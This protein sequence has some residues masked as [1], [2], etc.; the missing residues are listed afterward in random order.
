MAARGI[1]DADEAR[2]Y[3]QPRLGQLRAPGGLAGLT[4]AV[5]RLT[6]AV[7]GGERIGVFGDYDVD[8]VTTAALITSY[9]RQLGASVVPRV[10]RRDA[11]YGF[12]CADADFFAG[13]GC[14][15]VITG[16]CGTSDIDAIERAAARGM[17]VIVVD[18]HTVPARGSQHPALALINP[19]RG[20]ST[21]PFRAMASVGLS[22]YLMAALRTD[23]R[24]AGFFARRREPELR[25]LLDLVALGTVADLVPLQGENRILTATGLRYLS[26]R[27]RPG[28]A[29]LLDSAGVEQGRPVDERV[30]GWKLGP[31][32]NAPGRLGDAEPALALL[33]AEDPATA[34][35]WAERLETANQERRAAQDT[36]LAQALEQLGERDPGP[37]VVVAGRGWPC[38]VVGVV[39]ARLVDLYRRPALVIA[40]D[41]DSGRGRGSARGVEGIDLYKALE[42]CA[43]TL[44]RFGGHP[45]A[46]GVTVRESA[47][48]RLRDTLTQAV[49]QQRQQEQAQAGADVDA[50][51]ALAE[52]DERL[53][54]ELGSLAPFGKGNEE[55][56]LM[57]RGMRVRDSRRVGDGSHLKLEI[58]DGEGVALPG[59]GFGLGDSDPG[60]GATIDAAFAPVVSEWRGRR[61]VELEIRRLNKSRPA[62]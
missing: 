11:G 42:Q 48:D 54:Q 36:V 3:L 55:P 34:A 8:G 44:E 38:G 6:R 57:C 51:V 2:S 12:G 25:D 13:S 41:P 59:I 46:A 4:S 19:F 32:L 58:E 30:I 31:R 49:T 9:L 24:A 39:A 21:F 33:L 62:C 60:R 15:L 16:D 56:L 37:A 28:V 40:I 17:D 43:D 22:F 61:R 5:S 50:E 35:R 52:V 27:R 18:H 47:I 29:A 26:T 1:S 53:C 7:Q 45:A 14:R 10:A 20:D 23:L